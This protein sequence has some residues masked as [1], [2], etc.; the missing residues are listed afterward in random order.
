MTPSLRDRSALLNNSNPSSGR[1]SPFGGQVL[2]G[3][4]SYSLNQQPQFATRY[5]DDLESQNDEMLEGLSAKV[6]LLKDVRV[7]AHSASC[8][9]L[10][11]FFFFRFLL[12]LYWHWE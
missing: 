6:K 4:S 5:T 3:S 8:Q 9:K 12:D 2:N 7:F 11:T 1:S 10:E